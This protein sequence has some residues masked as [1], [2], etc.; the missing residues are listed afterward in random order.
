[1]DIQTGNLNYSSKKNEWI[2]GYFMDENSPLK[3]TNVEVKWI[4][5]KKGE[6]KKG[7]KNKVRSQTFIILISGKFIIRLPEKNKEFVLSK[8]GDFV[9]FDAS[10]S[11]HESET[12]ED[13][14]AVVIKWPSLPNNFQEH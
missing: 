10:K 9:T 4:V 14:K 2:I 3:T 13:S 11:L 5:R 8:E 12:I 7:I 6:I 1:M